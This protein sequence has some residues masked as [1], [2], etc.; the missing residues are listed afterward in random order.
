MMDP[1]GWMG[2]YRELSRW[3]KASVWAAL[4]FFLLANVNFAWE[5]CTIFGEPLVD[6]INSMISAYLWF[7]VIPW[8]GYELNKAIK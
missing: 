7:F 4:I 2:K 3:R 1:R 6:V 5:R 8:A